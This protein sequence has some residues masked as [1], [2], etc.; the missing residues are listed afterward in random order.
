MKHGNYFL[1]PEGP[2]DIERLWMSALP[3]PL[4]CLPEWLGIEHASMYRTL[5][6]PRNWPTSLVESKA[7]QAELN[8]LSE[9]GL[10]VETEPTD[11]REDRVYIRAPRTEDIWSIGIYTGKTFLDMS[12]SPD[13]LNPVLTREHVSD[14]AASYVADPFMLKSKGIWYMFFEVM[15]WKTCKGEIGLATSHNGLTWQYKQITLSEEFHLSYPYV[16]EWNG[17]FYMI[18]ES[19]QAGEVRL[20]HS[21]NFPEKWEFVS[22]LISGSYFVDASIFHHSEKWWL[23]VDSSDHGENDTL[24]LYMAD[25]LKG[26]WTEHPMSPIVQNDPNHARPAGR[27]LSFDGCLVRFAQN[28]VPNYGTDVRAFEITRLTESEY[29]ERLLQKVP[30]LRPSYQGWNAD[31]MHHIDAHRIG[32]NDWLASVDGW[33]RKTPS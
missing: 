12:P 31:G 29:Q 24:R 32:E 19:F 21:S 9:I 7:Y 27:V 28:S 13:V 23:I 11:R 16:F 26:P 17:Q 15:N 30:I 1:I 8:E 6:R 33:Y 22:T 18:P 3:L 5:P 25:E 2:D 20:Y 4:N 10:V 14:V